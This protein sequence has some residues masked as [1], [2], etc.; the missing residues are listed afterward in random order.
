[1][2]RNSPIRVQRVLEIVK[3]LV[4]S[5][6][7]VL[8]VSCGSGTILKGLREKGYTV[9]GTNY[10][11]YTGF[12]DIL[13]VDLG[14]DILKGL[15]YED[16]TYDC[17]ILHDVIEHLSDH[18]AAT[19]ELARVVKDGGHVVV[20]TPNIMKI[21]SRLN[22][23]LTGFF[24]SNKAFIGFDVPPDRAFGFHNYPAHLPTFLYQ[25]TSNR[26]ETVLVDAVGFKAKS[27]IMWLFFAPL[28]FPATYFRTHMFEKHLRKTTASRFLFKV[29][30][31]FKTLCGESWIV[32]GRKRGKAGKGE[33]ESTHLPSWS[34][35]C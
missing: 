9:R 8:E 1:M 2:S 29:L 33:A 15:P 27:W 30:T 23:F 21:N 24:K 6:S 35:R 26:V 34:E 28:V 22:F 32:V 5:G 17:V 13:P 3:K 16:G 7:S 4:P 18:T 10:T 25:L 20:A 14:V 19:R 12:E 31:S 11:K